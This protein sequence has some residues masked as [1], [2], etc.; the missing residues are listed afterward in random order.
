MLCDV[1][2]VS[3][4]GYSDSYLLAKGVIMTTLTNPWTPNEDGD[5]I[6]VDCDEAFEKQDIYGDPQWSDPRCLDCYE[7]HRYER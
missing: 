3:P 1:A 2:I 7:T 4:V 5:I 6:C